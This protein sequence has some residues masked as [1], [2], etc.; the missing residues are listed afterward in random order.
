MTTPPTPAGWYPDPEHSGGLRYWDGVTWTEHRTPAQ[1]A[2]AAGRPPRASRRPEPRGCPPS[3][4]EPPG[5]RHDV[6]RPSRCRRAARAWHRAQPTIPSRRRPDARADPRA[7]APCRPPSSRRRRCRCAE[8]APYATPPRRRRPSRRGRAARGHRAARPGRQPQ[9]GD[10]IRRRRRRTAAGV[11]PRRRLR[12]RHSQARHRATQLVPTTETSA[13]TTRR[14]RRR[15][16]SHATEAA[17]PPAA[18]AGRPAEFTV[19]GVDSGTTV[20]DPANEFLTKDAQ[21]E[22][23]VVRLTVQNT[24]PD[25]GQFL[26]TFQKLKAAARCTPSTTRPLS[27]SAAASWTSR[28]AARSTSALPT[29]CRPAPYPNRLSCTPTLPSPGCRAA[30]AKPRR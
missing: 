22:F 26:G 10:G 8:P 2:P 21:G 30:D 5:H 4:P 16:Q 20:T 17:P 12:V 3:R 9:A 11:G 6:G 25:P 18:G 13:T 28:P 27:T 1:E 14:R 15:R 29:T 19:T 23:I 24:S 7:D